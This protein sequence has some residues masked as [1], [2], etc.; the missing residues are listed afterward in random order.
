VEL[1]ARML[2]LAGAAATPAEAMQRI[3]QAISSGE[4]LERLRR[5]ID[6]QGGDPRVLDDYGRLP[7]APGRQMVAAPRPGFVTTVDAQTIGRAAVALGAG[8]DRVDDRID[9]AV[10]IVVHAKPGDRVDAGDPVLELHYRT[11]DRRDMA[12]ALVARGVTI[13]D[14]PPDRRPLIV[15]RLQ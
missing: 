3:R 1:A 2:L 12:L 4:A 15:A 6:Y 9:P 14:R 10:G 13:D 7:A 5:V 8:R 11:I